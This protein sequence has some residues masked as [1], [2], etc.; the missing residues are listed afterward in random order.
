MGDHRHGPWPCRVIETLGSAPALL[1]HLRRLVLKDLHL[2]Q[3]L[4]ENSKQQGF[5]KGLIT[6]SNYHQPF[7]VGLAIDFGG[8]TDLDHLQLRWLVSPSVTWMVLPP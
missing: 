8:V 3:K 4:R 5:S 6:T 7:T 1:R 2:T